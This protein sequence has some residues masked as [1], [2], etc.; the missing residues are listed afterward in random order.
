M[1]TPPRNRNMIKVVMSFGME[2]PIDETQTGEVAGACRPVIRPW[3]CWRRSPAV[4][5]R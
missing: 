1:P 5:A 3:R 4:S 2:V